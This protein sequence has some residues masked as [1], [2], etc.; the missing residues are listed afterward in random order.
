[1]D[2]QDTE[3]AITADVVL[4]AIGRIPNVEGLG[5]ENAG[6]NLVAGERQE[7]SPG[8][9][10]KVKSAIAVDEYSRTSVPNILLWEI[11]PTGSI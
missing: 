11:A 9:G 2:G 3:M 6:V 7:M 10:Y 5:L 4:A 1:M 8:T